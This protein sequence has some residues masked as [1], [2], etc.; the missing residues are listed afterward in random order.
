[1]IRVIP[2]PELSSLNLPQFRYENIH[3]QPD[4]SSIEVLPRW[5]CLSCSVYP[6]SF[7][8]IGGIYDTE[9]DF[10]DVGSGISIAEL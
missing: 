7:L 10:T 8:I 9:T 3:Y 6:T 5:G 2:S 1:M 4:N